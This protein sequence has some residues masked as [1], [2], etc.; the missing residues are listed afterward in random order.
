MGKSDALQ[1]PS[2][3]PDPVTLVKHSYTQ[4]DS[5]EIHVTMLAKVSFCVTV[6]RYSWLIDNPGRTTHR[7]FFWFG[8][9]FLFSVYYGVSSMI[10]VLKNFR[11][12]IRI[13][14]SPHTV[15]EL[16]FLFLKKSILIKKIFSLEN[17]RKINRMSS[18]AS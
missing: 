4:R 16:S 8:F 7:G 6:K 18:F 13:V 17:N 5:L 10:H 2:S 3:V 1:T 9:F 11:A 14:L 12:A 15:F